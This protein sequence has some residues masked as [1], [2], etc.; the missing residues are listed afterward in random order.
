[1]NE[2]APEPEPYRE[3]FERSAD[4]TFIIE[5]DTFIECNQAAVDMLRYATKEEAL[6]THPSELSP[7]TQPDGRDSFEK[8]NEMIARAFE[9]GSH[10][11]EWDHKRADGEVFPVEVLL[12]AVRRQERELLHVVWR[13]ITE[14]KLLEEQLRQSQKMEAVGKLAGGIAHDF[15][16]LLVVI[17]GNSDLLQRPLVEQPALLQRV[18]EIRH[19]ADRAADLVRHLLAFSRKQELRR[20]VVNLAEELPNLERLLRRLIGEDIKLLLEAPG[21]AHRVSVDLGQ[22]EQ[23]IINL[24]TNASDAIVGGGTITLS[25]SRQVVED[26]GIVALPPGP[27]VVVTVTD[28]GTG[29]DADTA[30]RAFEPFFTTKDIGKGTGLGLAT[31]YGAMQQAGG[32]VTIDSSLGRGTALKIFLPDV[33][34]VAGSQDA[35][36]LQLPTEGGSETILMVEDEHVV[37]ATVERTLHAKGYTV[38]VAHDGIEGLATWRDNPAR[39]DLILSDVVMPRMGGPE[40]VS[41]IRNEGGSARVLFMSGH[42]DDSLSFDG[43]VDLLEKPFST[44]E[45]AG[46]IRQCLDRKT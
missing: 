33:T 25:L 6:R 35:G 12:T 23:A 38:L 3:L 20:Q 39:I 42:T 28:T 37:A 21:T 1:M 30:R 5:G 8:A 31:V 4:A 44:T 13:D 43:E 19:A 46:R 16:N 9:H 32:T 11:F 34:N 45:L 18:N 10:R 27:Y 17:I 40:M 41:R 14:R 22:L 36:S 29:M 15:N 2:E 24:V 7:P 26:G